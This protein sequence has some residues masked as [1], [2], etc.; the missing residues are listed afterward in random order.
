MCYLSLEQLVDQGVLREVRL[1]RVEIHQQLL[2]LGGWQDRY[3]L[4]QSLRVANQ[5][6]DQPA[7][8]SNQIGGYASRIDPDYG[9]SGQ[10]ETG[11][12]IIHRQGERIVALFLNGDHAYT[13]PNRVN[14]VCLAGL[15]MTVIKQGTEQW[16]RLRHAT[17]ALCQRQR[18]LLVLQQRH[19]IAVG[20]LHHFLHTAAGQRDSYWQGIDKHPQYTISASD[21]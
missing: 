6:I 13:C 7:D 9:L 19:Q 1:S 21:P 18:C 12:Q 10:V 16:H 20:G 17:T 8:G 15:A 4:N 2:P 5:G 11:S 14:R 3:I